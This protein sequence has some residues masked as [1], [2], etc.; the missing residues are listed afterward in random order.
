MHWQIIRKTLRSREQSGGAGGLSRQRGFTLIELMLV[1]AVMGI[2]LAIGIPTLAQVRNHESFNGVVSDIADV[3]SR[4]RAQS[5]LHGSITE[6]VIDTQHGR[7]SLHDVGGGQD[8]VGDTTGVAPARPT[9]DTGGLTDSAQLSSHVDIDGLLVN[10]ADCRDMPEVHVRFYP[11]GTCD[12]MILAL[13]GDGGEHRS[14]V[15]EEV[16]ALP[17]VKNTSDLLAQ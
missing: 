14:V 9:T 15:L 2:L 7:F 12:G 16:T 17:T 13:R 3:C 5:I 4:A 11:N 6:L 8:Y 10:F 1:V